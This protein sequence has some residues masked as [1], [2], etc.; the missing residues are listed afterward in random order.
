MMLVNILTTL[1]TVPGICNALRNG[2]KPFAHMKFDFF[3]PEFLLHIL[4]LLTL[5]TSVLKSAN[6]FSIERNV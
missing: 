5:S 1:S 2:V 4:P 6:S 3:L